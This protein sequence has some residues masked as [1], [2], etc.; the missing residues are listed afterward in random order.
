MDKAKILRLC[1]E[2]KYVV[3]ELADCCE[4]IDLHTHTMLIDKLRGIAAEISEPPRSNADYIRQMTDEELADKLT[5]KC[6]VCA[7]HHAE[8]EIKLCFCEEGVLKW[9]KQEV[10]G[11][12][13]CRN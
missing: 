1:N 5:D 4:I 12:R 7:F 6:A 9:L 11:E 2:I 3:N 8:C 10:S 13:R